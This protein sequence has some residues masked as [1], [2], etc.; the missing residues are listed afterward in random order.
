VAFAGGE[1]FVGAPR[2]DLLGRDEGAIYVFRREGETQWVQVAKL[3][4]PD[5]E[6]DDRV[7]VS[8]AVDGGRMIIGAPYAR[9]WLGK[10]YIFRRQ[11]DEAW[12]SEARLD[13]DPAGEVRFF[14]RSVDLRGNV[15]ALGSDEHDGNNAPSA[16]YVFARRGDGTW[17]QV[18][19][20]RASDTRRG[21]EFGR[22]VVLVEEGLLATEAP[23]TGRPA[24]LFALPCADV[25]NDGFIDLADLRSFYNCLTGPGGVVAPSC[26][27]A[28]LDF[29]GDA[30]LADFRILQVAFEQRR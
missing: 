25:D 12:V 26:L 3:T 11:E 30:D 9:G 15:A 4:A 23:W 6:N 2:A 16:A 24:H 29:D 19:A 18:A 1:L 20:V 14:G 22:S 13:P 8:L 27:R 7:G 28:D 5:A 10:A 21:D 17:V